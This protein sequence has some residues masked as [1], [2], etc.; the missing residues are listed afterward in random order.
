[1]DIEKIHAKLITTGLIKD[2]HFTTKLILKWAKSPHQAVVRFANYLFFSRYCFTNANNNGDPFVWN[3]IMKSFSHGNDPQ[4][5]LEVFILMLENGVLVDK[6]SFSLV[7]KACSRL[8]SVKYG[9]QVHGLLRKFEFGTDLFLE[10]CLISMYIKCG[11]I[12]FGRQVFDR[13]MKKDSFL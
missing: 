3:S 6:Y 2:P 9:M 5:A 7:L 11:C 8:G 4:N 10:N 1:M 13:I 12:A